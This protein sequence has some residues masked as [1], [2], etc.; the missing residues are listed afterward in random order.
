[1]S[2]LVMTVPIVFLNASSEVTSDWLFIV[3]ES[4]PSSSGELKNKWNVKPIKKIMWLYI[5]I[6]VYIERES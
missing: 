1:M 3:D 5:Y 4:A 6:Y 2:R